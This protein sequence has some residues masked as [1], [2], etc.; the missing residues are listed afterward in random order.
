M[1][2]SQGG[3]I[4]WPRLRLGWKGGCYPLLRDGHRLECKYTR[5]LGGSRNI[6]AF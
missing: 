1:V 3:V 6:T 2:R 4:G 5:E